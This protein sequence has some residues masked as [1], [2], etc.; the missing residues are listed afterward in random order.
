MDGSA[1]LRL[2]PVK[3]SDVN[4]RNADKIL[5]DNIFMRNV[6]VGVLVTRKLE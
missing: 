2:Q 1:G 4:R 6:G 3:V 5:S